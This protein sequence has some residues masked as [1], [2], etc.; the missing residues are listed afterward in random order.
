MNP[1]VHF[2]MP[3]RDMKRSLD[4]YSKVFG[5]ESK[6][7][8]EEMGNYAVVTTTEMGKDGWPVRKGTINGGF[9]PRVEEMDK[10]SVVIAVEDIK[11]HMK[12]VIKAGGKVLGE[13]NNIPGI[14][15]Y[16]SFIDTEGNKVSMI[17]PDMKSKG[18]Q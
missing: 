18:P 16:V 7:Y 4:F 15:L 12:K 2:E 13:P 8:G 5:W 9:F 6:Q 14:G 10:P 1:V 17:Q 11:V 3:A